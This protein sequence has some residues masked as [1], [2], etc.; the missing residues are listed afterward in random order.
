MVEEKVEFYL[1]KLQKSGLSDKSINTYRFLLSY[2]EE[3]ANYYGFFT[4]DLN[5]TE[6]DVERF[7][8]FL[9]SKEFVSYYNQDGSK[10]SKRPCRSFRGKMESR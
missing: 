7:I 2:F 9:K 1:K 4:T 8:T 3:W 5:L 10:Q 6:N